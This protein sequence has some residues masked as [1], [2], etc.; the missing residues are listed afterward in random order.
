MEED[1]RSNGIRESKRQYL[2]S[3]FGGYRIRCPGPPS[4]TS[5]EWLGSRHV[6]DND[7]SNIR[8]LQHG[9]DSY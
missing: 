1:I 9:D 2:F 4:G 5:N 8:L 6:H 7:W 3:M